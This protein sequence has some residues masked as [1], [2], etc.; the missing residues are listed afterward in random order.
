MGGG[1][2]HGRFAEWQWEGGA[3]IP[4][5]PVVFVVGAQRI[6]G[7]ADDQIQCGVVEI[8]EVNREPFRWAKA[9]GH[10]LDGAVIAGFGQHAGAGTVSL[11]SQGTWP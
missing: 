1:G 5:G 7:L 10:L 3:C 9:A 11:R 2:Q 8:G 6:A 4:V